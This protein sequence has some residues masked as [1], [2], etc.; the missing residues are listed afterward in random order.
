[1][2]LSHPAHASK[3][4]F[5][6]LTQLSLSIILWSVWGTRIVMDGRLRLLTYQ[7]VQQNL[8]T[9]GEHRD[10]A[11]PDPSNQYLLKRSERNSHF[12]RKETQ[13]WWYKYFSNLFWSHA[14]ETFSNFWRCGRWGRMTCNT[15]CN[16]CRLGFRIGCYW[17]QGIKGS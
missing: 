12:K 9:S 6:D 15:C 16:R 13:L 10:E 7:A 11:P 2:W 5:S 14:A 8:N 4:S 3:I 17:N 1:M